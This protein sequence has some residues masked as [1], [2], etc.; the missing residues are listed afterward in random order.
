MSRRVL[1]PA[2]ALGLLPV[3]SSCGTSDPS[4]V[5][6]PPGGSPAASAAT[7]A[8]ASGGATAVASGVPN[9]SAQ[10]TL[11][12]T[13]SHGKVSGDTGRVPVKL[14]TTLRITVLSDVS[15]EIHVHVYDLTQELA[16]GEP[17]F[18]QFTADKPGV[19][20]VELEHEGIPLTHLQVQ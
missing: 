5:A 16:A 15:D 7:S 12:F 8:S 9:D 19:I 11:S 10:Q 4:T 18:V 14:G 6:E 2:L 13:V 3:L 20:E 17:G 1:L